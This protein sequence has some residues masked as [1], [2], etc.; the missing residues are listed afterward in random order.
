VRRSRYDQLRDVLLDRADEKLQLR[1]TRLATSGR[2]TRPAL[3][4]PGHPPAGGPSDNLIPAARTSHMA[5][6]REGVGFPSNRGGF[7][8]SRVRLDGSDSLVL[9]RR[10]QRRRTVPS[11]DVVEV[12][13]PGDDDGPRIGPVRKWCRD[14]TSCSRLEKNASEAALSKHYPAN[15]W[16]VLVVNRLH[17]TAGSGHQVCGCGQFRDTPSGST[18]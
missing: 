9:V 4:G 10:Q 7:L 17:T 6:H 2:G 18:S 11:C 5:T 8:L 14:S 1:Q 16:A 15:R 12:L 13:A 3:P